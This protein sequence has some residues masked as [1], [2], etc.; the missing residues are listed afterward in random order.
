MQWMSSTRWTG[1]K[2][3]LS[4][5]EAGKKGWQRDSLSRSRHILTLFPEVRCEQRKAASQTIA[6]N[7]TSSY[8]ISLSVSST[9]FVRV[10]MNVTRVVMLTLGRELRDHHGL[11]TINNKLKTP[12][13]NS[14]SYHPIE[15]CL[16]T[17]YQSWPFCVSRF[18]PQLL[19]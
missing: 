1:E 13:M 10:N 2:E 6:S 15:P 9:R 19:R 3:E 5:C 17:C 7:A 12:T 14:S 18:P 16:V 4:G 11:L 8:L